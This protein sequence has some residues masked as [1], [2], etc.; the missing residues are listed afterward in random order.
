MGPPSVC[1]P[2]G[3]LGL[4]APVL[5]RTC[6]VAGG[7]LDFSAVFTRSSD[8]ILAAS[9]LAQRMAAIRSSFSG[10]SLIS[11]GNVVIVPN[12]IR[13][14]TIP[15]GP[16]ESFSAFTTY[17]RRIYGF[18]DGYRWLATLKTLRRGGTVYFA[19]ANGV[20]ELHSRELQVD[21]VRC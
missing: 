18:R 3:I 7:N 12:T 2:L 6:L 1:C 4:F 11:R 16:M 15:S 9:S 10:S 19:R 5:S 20:M 8:V 13:D 17:R 21:S 14:G